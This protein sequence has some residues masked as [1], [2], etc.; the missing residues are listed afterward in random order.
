[1][2]LI[3]V[4][5]IFSLYT[6]NTFGLDSSFGDAYVYQPPLLK[7]ALIVVGLVGLFAVVLLWKWKRLGLYIL[8]ATVFLNAFLNPMIL[9]ILFGIIG[10]GILCLAIKPVWKNFN[11]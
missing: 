3:T 8:I 6:L 7:L 9:P 10:T 5:S 11:Y 2:G 4:S 1:M